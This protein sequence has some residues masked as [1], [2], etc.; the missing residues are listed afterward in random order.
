MSTD[1]HRGLADG[2][3]RGGVAGS[4]YALEREQ[5]AARSG[6]SCGWPDRIPTAAAALMMVK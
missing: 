1:R 2:C 6:D 4:S 5:S 3:H